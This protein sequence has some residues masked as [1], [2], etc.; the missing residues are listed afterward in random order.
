MARIM[1]EECSFF[2]PLLTEHLLLGTPL[3]KES[4]RHVEECPECTREVSD[5]GEVVRTLR[6]ADPLSG[7]TG[8][9]A[10]ETPARPSRDLSDRIRREVTGSKT[11]RPR[12]RRRIALGV[13]AAFVTAAAAVFPLA[14]DRNPS[15]APSVVLVRQGRMIE[16]PWGTEVPVALSGL[17]AGEMYRLMA[18]NADGRRAPGGSVQTTSGDRV[19][20]RMVTG[21]RKDTITALIVE[22]EEGHIVTR[23]PVLPYPSA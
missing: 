17:E 15:P 4:S 11:A 12:P 19:S 23:V 18:V 8:A 13:A 20:T 2:R 5:L 1:N 6:R 3:P 9:Q 14:A 7:W 10:S 16:R 21:M 22:D